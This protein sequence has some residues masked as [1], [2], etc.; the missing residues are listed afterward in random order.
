MVGVCVIDSGGIIFKWQIIIILVFKFL[1][2]FGDG[3]L[4]RELL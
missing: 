4:G 1:K 2:C 3:G